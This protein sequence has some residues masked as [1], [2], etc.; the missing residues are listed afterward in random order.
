VKPV[1]CNL[2]FAWPDLERVLR[3]P[4]VTLAFFVGAALL[5]SAVEPT[6]AQSAPWERPICMVARSLSGPVAKAVAIIA[7][8]I[9]GL[10]IAFSEVGGLFKTLLGLLGGASFALLADQWL[11]FIRT[12]AGSDCYSAAID[13][14]HYAQALSDMAA[15]ALHVAWTLV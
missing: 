14:P 11:G 5:L 10:L 7:I 9:T 2:H 12:G 15:A 6:L 8:V 13:V 1:S 4:C 3:R